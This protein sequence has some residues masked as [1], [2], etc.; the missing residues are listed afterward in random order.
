ML[1]HLNRADGDGV[2]NFEKLC[3]EEGRG[4]GV[5]VVSNTPSHHAIGLE[6]ELIILAKEGNVKKYIR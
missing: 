4:G 3:S 5:T 2:L 6:G 1:T